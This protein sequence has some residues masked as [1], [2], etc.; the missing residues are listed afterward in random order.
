[1]IVI[2][3]RLLGHSDGFVQRKQV[4]SICRPRARQGQSRR[5]KTKSGRQIS[6]LKGPDYN[7]KETK[8]QFIYISGSDFERLAFSKMTNKNNA[9]TDFK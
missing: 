6:G 8:E 7:G 9:K 4:M 2:S 1:L 5:M 3:L